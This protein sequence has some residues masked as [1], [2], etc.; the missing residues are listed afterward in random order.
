MIRVPV[1]LGLLALP[2]LVACDLTAPT[3]EAEFFFPVDYPDVQLSDYALAGQI[4]DVTSP[5]SSAPAQQDISGLLEELLSDD[6]TGLTL[7]VITESD[8]DVTAAMTLTISTNSSPPAQATG[9][10]PLTASTITV[11]LTASQG[12]DTT[13]VTADHLALRN[14]ASLTYETQGT[15]RGGPGGTTVGPNDR[16][17]VDVNLLA[18]YRVRP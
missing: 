4:P 16:I 9:G 6:L 12:V 17:R 7:E 18:R 5:F 14:A 1:R 8:V 15:L 2:A 3:W 13:T 10:A 11:Q